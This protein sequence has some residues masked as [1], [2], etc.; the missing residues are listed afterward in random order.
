MA[1]LWGGRAGGSNPCWFPLCQS[2]NLHG[3]PTT[4]GGV[5]GC[6]NCLQR[7]IAMKDAVTA[8]SLREILDYDPETGVFRRKVRASNAASGS[9]AGSIMNGYVAISIGNQRYKAHRLAWLYVY[10]SWPKMAIDHINGNRA[11][12]RI[13]NIRL[14]TQRMNREN[15]HS[16]RSD[17]KS[18]GML[19]AHWCEYHKKWKS[20]I[21]THGKLIHIG[22]F[23]TAEEAH[24]KYL[25]AKRLLHEGCTI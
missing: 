13:Y 21:R 12:N 8:D 7:R 2:A 16:A 15:L 18:S 5:A 24:Q 22:Y 25:E 17:N 3:Q 19:G 6:E 20:H 23:K 4:L 14:A 9:V 11:D 1:F 10:G